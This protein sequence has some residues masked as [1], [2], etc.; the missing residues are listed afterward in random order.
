MAFVPLD[1]NP[2]LLSLLA[3]INKGVES[4]HK[5]KGIPLLT[6]RLIS[7]LAR[8]YYLTNKADFPFSYSPAI[9]FRANTT[10]SEAAFTAF[11]FD[12]LT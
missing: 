11:L 9:A 10:F 8:N 6:I 4:W 5:R 7:P 2:G 12:Y 1:T 3:I